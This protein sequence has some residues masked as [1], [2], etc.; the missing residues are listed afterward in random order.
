MESMQFCLFVV[1]R[2]KG[3]GGDV[4]QPALISY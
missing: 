2:G 3:M 4:Y 1:G